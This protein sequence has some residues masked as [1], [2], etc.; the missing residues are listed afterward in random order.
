[1]GPRW[2]VGRC[3]D[4]GVSVTV[5]GA[6]QTIRSWKICFIHFLPHAWRAMAC[7]CDDGGMMGQE[8]LSVIVNLC[9]KKPV[10]GFCP[11]TAGS[12]VDP[13]GARQQRQQ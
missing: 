3:G 7:L 13:L 10:V 8:T 5:P 12:H 9:G 2:K 1:M 11:S 4:T 6:A